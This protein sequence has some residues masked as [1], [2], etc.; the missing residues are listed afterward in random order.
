MARMSAAGRLV[1]LARNARNRAGGL[2]LLRTLKDGEAKAVVFDPQY[3]G[4]LDHMGY[5]NEGVGRERQRAAL[6]AMNDAAIFSFVGEIARALAPSRYLFMW[7]D[8]F[9]VGSGGHLRYLA[10]APLQVVDLIAWSKCRIGMGRRARCTTEYVVVA[11]KAP[12]IA[13]GTWSDHSLP[14]SWPEQA[15]R[16]LHPHAK[17]R[18]LTER[19]IR[20]ATKRGDLVV[21]PCAG[22]YVTLDA[23]V[24]SGR[25]FLGCDLV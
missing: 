5:G 20:A 10:A 13:K 4:L 19:L 18:Q 11:Q 22:S 24:A 8:K 3:R 2:G 9:A 1:P 15:D 25:Q 23:C 14:D 12:V 21:D 16:S 7:A 17:P 6:P